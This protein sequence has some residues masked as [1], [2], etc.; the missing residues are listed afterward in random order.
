MLRRTLYIK[1]ISKPLS[2]PPSKRRSAMKVNVKGLRG[3]V[4][5]RE[6]HLLE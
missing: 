2:M 1:P 3:E 5:I 6:D 4:S